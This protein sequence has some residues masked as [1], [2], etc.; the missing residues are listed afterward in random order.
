MST[1]VTITDFE[2]IPTGEYAVQ[3]ADYDEETG[4]QYG[5]QVKFSLEIIKGEFAGKTLFYWCGIK[6]S[7]KSK[8][9]KAA[10]A[11]GMPVETGG[12]LR[13]EDFQGRKAIAVVIVETRDDKSEI[14]KVVDVKMPR[15]KPVPAP[16][17]VATAE[18]DPFDAE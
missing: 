9:V 6:G 2:P 12:T 4:G 10:A 7:R 18:A 13:L 11:F 15:S 14:S 17:A 1:Q 5:P 8:L 3:V 16:V